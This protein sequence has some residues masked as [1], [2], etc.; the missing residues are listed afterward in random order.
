[1]N[2]E[3]MDATFERL[4][5]DQDATVSLDFVRAAM[6]SRD[7]EILGTLYQFLCTEHGPAAIAPPLGAGELTGFASRYLARCLHEDPLAV[8]FI[9][10][11]ACTRYGAGWEVVRWYVRLHKAMPPETEALA[12]L[13]AMLAGLY[14]EGDAAL[15]SAIAGGTLAHLF[16]SNAVRRTFSEWKS[17]PALR[18]AYRGALPAFDQRTRLRARRLQP[19]TKKSSTAIRT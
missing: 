12:S 2:I 18:A 17:D 6:Q 19:L 10:Q 15:R 4:K 11:R 13:R 8:D 3:R 7:L 5:W 14:L 9:A 16:A 1:M